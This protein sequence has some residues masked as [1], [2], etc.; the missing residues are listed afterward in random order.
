MI[1]DRVKCAMPYAPGSGARVG[2][3]VSNKQ[4]QPR[5]I[6]SEFGVFGNDAIFL[7]IVMML[8]GHLFCARFRRA[9]DA[10]QALFRN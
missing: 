10:R 8:A 7:C 6:V 5:A 4:S 1:T 9:E 2:S 3:N